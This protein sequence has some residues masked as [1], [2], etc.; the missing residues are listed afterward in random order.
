MFEQISILIPFKEDNGIR[1]ETLQWVIRFYQNVIPEAEICIG[2]N[3]DKIFNRC[4]AINAAAEKASRNVFVLAD[5]DVIYDPDLLVE[6]VLSL[7]KA[8]WVIPFNRILDISQKKTEEILKIEPSWPLSLTNENYSEFK[9]D[10]LFAG[11]LNVLSREAFEKVGGYD[12]QFLGWGCEDDAFLLAMNTLSGQFI[13]MNRPIYHFWHPF[14]G[15]DNNPYY[16]KNLK[17]LSR[18][19]QANG[20]PIRMQKLIRNNRTR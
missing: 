15:A 18:Y 5:A 11:K 7:Q 13:N 3:D 4:K 1:S 17:R 6:S 8:P 14:V 10:K 2:E 9:I 16:R 19:Q 20:N 12:E